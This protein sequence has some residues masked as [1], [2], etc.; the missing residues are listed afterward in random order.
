MWPLSVAAHRGLRGCRICGPGFG[1]CVEWAGTS[2]KLHRMK[3]RVKEGEMC[4][5]VAPVNVVTGFA[6]ST[7]PC[8]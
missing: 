7:A 6:V 1:V 2:G 4:K 5:N 8:P 3:A